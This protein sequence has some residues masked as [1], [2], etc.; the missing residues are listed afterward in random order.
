MKIFHSTLATLSFKLAF[1]TSMIYMIINF[2]KIIP[3][4]SWLTRGVPPRDYLL[5]RKVVMAVRNK[6]IIQGA[7][8]VNID[9][10]KNAEYQPVFHNIENWLN[11]NCSI[12]TENPVSDLCQI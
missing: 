7:E 6:I 1:G 10:G 9:S 4:S 2:G 8:A 11:H 12:S 3:F 5:R